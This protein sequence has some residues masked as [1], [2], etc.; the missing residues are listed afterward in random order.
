MHRLF[1]LFGLSLTG[2]GA[3]FFMGNVNAA[4]NGRVAFA[5]T[6]RMP[7]MS[8]VSA[9]TTGN[10]TTNT[11][12]TTAVRCPD[13]GVQNSE[14]TIDNCMTDV[15]ACINNGALPNGLN[16]LFNEDL[17]NSILNGMSLCA[18]Q[19]DTCLT[20]VR[21]DCNNVYRS[22]ADFWLDFNSRKV[23]PE[24]YSF[25]LRKT[26]LTPNQAENTCWLLDKNV[27]GSSFDAVANDGSVT[28]EY[29]RQ[30]GAYNSQGGGVLTKDSPQGVAV[31]NNAIGVDGQRGHY[32]RW[33]AT[34]GECLVRVAAYNR[35]S[36]IKNSWLFGAAGNDQPAEVW[37]SAG[38]S[39]SCN[40]DLFGFGLMKNTST[41]AVVGIGGGAVVGGTVGAIAGH[42]ER[43]FDCDVKE[44]RES[45]TKELRYNESVTDLNAYL[46]KPLESLSND[47][48]SK[49]QCQDIKDLYTKYSKLKS[50]VAQD[51]D[52]TVEK[53]TT[54]INSDNFS[55]V[56]CN[57]DEPGEN[58]CK[59]GKEI[60]VELKQLEKIFGDL[61]TLTDVEDSNMFASTAIGV[62]AGAAAGGLATAITA[63]VEKN[64]I[65]CRVGDGLKKVDYGKSY[66]IDSLKEFYVK[67]NLRLPDTIMPTATATDCASWK[68][69]CA[70]LTDLNQ[71]A[72]AQI[73]YRPIGSTNTQLV[74]T[75]C[76]VSGSTCID[77]HPVAVS[78]GACE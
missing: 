11:N 18:T 27:Y 8:I 30:I 77:N 21:R 24:Y 71:C 69:A 6:Q 34:A 13:G 43:Y 46:G 56:L 65:N 63:F 54:L 3:V 10:V 16:D 32:A 55:D 58:T 49:R 61:Y 48:M 19:V 64:N 78:Y 37:R 70:T 66:S 62:G 50:L 4:E 9:N 41:V 59:T 67:W 29:N 44:N 72:V 53:Y 39:F 40:K 38:S 51:T 74:D 20:N 47:T 1:K 60:T 28:S 33:D 15:L 26:G 2:L 75:A 31:N 17:R 22:S 35:N 5:S 45:L 76:V 73:N 25:V 14:Y 7:T 23:Q 52:G 68:A 36:Q 57:V 42:G 12:T